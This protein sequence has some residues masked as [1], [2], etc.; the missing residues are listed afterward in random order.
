MRDWFGTSKFRSL[1]ALVIDG[2]LITFF[3]VIGILC[4]YI[5]IFAPIL[6]LRIEIFGFLLFLIVI[7]LI[8]K[9]IPNTKKDWKRYLRFNNPSERENICSLCGTIKSNSF[10][11][12]PNC[13]SNTILFENPNGR[14]GKSK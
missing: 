7:I 14:N 4:L 2:Y 1:I 8:I 3:L 13:D 5:I 6:S 9:I 11:E 12:C 10:S